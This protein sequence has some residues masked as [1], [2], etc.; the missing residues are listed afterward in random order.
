MPIRHIQIE[1]AD[2][3]YKKVIR[4][5]GNR[6]WVEYILSTPEQFDI[7]DWKERVKSRAKKEYA[8]GIDDVM[9]I[10]AEELGK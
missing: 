2:E 10:A 9:N 5:K 6:T 3:D 4:L 7:E 1:L 8:G